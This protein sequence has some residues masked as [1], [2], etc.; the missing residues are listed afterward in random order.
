MVTATLPDTARASS[1]RFY[2]PEI[3]VLRFCGFLM[4]FLFHSIP[5]GN[6]HRFLVMARTFAA[7]SVP[8][9]FLLSSYLI[10]TLLLIE[11]RRTGQVNLRNFYVRRILRIWP[12][13]FAFLAICATFGHLDASESISASGLVA[14]AL[15]IGNWW[16]GTHGALS[17][18]T[19]PLWTLA[20]EEQFYVVWPWLVHRLSA[21]HVMAISGCVWISSQ[22]GAAWLCHHHIDTLQFWVSTLS[23]LQFFAVGAIVAAF[24]N[25]SMPRFSVPARI[26]LLLAA[27]AFIMAG[28]ARIPALHVQPSYG[29]AGVA[30]VLIGP[31]VACLLLAF[32]GISLPR[33]ASPFAALGRISFGAYVFHE[34]VLQYTAVLRQH[35]LHSQ[36]G[37][38]AIAWL[39]ALPITIAIAWLSYR[40]F[41]TPFLKLKSNFEVVHS[42]PA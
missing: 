37:Q 23:Q 38:I 5:L 40:Y 24:L 26:G 3:D 4:V 6:P 7:G 35:V 10:T 20:V 2:R 31:G 22:L 39:V 19:G 30:F 36:Q 18:M 34:A 41:E 29:S 16:S 32:L 15:L 17:L 13:Y 42:R 12:L 8:L 21:K 1:R 9:F 14:Y 28:T 25:G 33:F 27:L 11:R